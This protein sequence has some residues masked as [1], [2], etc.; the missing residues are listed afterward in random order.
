M[1]V[2]FLVGAALG[3]AAG[4]PRVR[5]AVRQGLVYGVGGILVAYDRVSSLA[6]GVAKDA[7]QSA[8]PGDTTPPP[9]ESRQPTPEGH[10]SDPEAANAPA[11]V[12]SVTTIRPGA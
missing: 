9:D 7:R 5:K 3:V 4:S 1:P 12:T 6:H 10:V 8:A 2:D 11:A